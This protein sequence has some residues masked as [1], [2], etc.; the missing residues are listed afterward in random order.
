MNNLAHVTKT[1]NENHYHVVVE[2]R[3]EEDVND[4]QLLGMLLNMPG[5]A[6]DILYRLSQLPKGS[7]FTV[8]YN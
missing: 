3:I 2:G 7:K 1:D 5:A 8:P 6:P 4:M